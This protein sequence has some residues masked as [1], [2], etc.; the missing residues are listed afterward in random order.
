MRDYVVDIND[1][2][3]EELIDRVVNELR[4][5]YDYDKYLLSTFVD[6]SKE[7]ISEVTIS[8]NS[9]GGDVSGFSRIKTEIDK[10][11]ELGIHIKTHVTHLAASCAFLILLLGDERSGSEFCELMNH[12]STTVNYGKVTS[13]ARMAEFHLELED[14]F[15]KFIVDRTN[16]DRKWLDENSE[17]DQWFNYDDAIELGIFTTE[18]ELNNEIYLSETV[19]QLTASGY[20]VIDDIHKEYEDVVE[21][22][23]VKKPKR[24]KKKVE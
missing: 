4:G 8:I 11:K 12:V 10:L 13:N 9:G 23:E 5:I 14:R 2:I 15:T 7:I 17:I 19:S 24:I 20:N 22:V 21:E 3:S 1:E 6:P 18:E 16:I